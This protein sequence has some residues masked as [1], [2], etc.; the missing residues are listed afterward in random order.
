MRKVSVVIS[1]TSRP[2][3]R[4]WLT[5]SFTSVVVL[6][7]PG[8]PTSAVM[9]PISGWTVKREPISSIAAAIQEGASGVRARDVDGR[10]L[11][12]PA[13][14]GPLDGVGELR[15]DAGFHER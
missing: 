6:P 10:A 11:A 13:A 5:A 4:H 9:R 7:E 8:G 15:V 1:S 3:R 2:W 12:N 14:G